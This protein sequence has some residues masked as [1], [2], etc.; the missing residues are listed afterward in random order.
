MVKDVCS[1]DVQKLGHEFVVVRRQ[2]MLSQTFVSTE[3]VDHSHESAKPLFIKTSSPSS[4]GIAPPTEVHSTYQL[5]GGL[6]FSSKL[7][8]T[9][10]PLGGVYK[11]RSALLG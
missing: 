5:L 2:I 7:V 3:G 6:N 10:R 9:C 4:Y 11:H 8:C 1:A